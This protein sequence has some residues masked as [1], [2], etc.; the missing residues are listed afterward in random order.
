[1]KEEARNESFIADTAFRVEA[2]YQRFAVIR[3]S[4]G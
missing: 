2:S 1:V 3:I 4:A